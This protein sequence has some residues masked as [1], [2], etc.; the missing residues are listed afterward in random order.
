MYRL[1]IL[2]IF[3]LSIPLNAHA[4]TDPPVMKL[5]LTPDMPDLGEEAKLRIMMHGSLTGIATTSAKIQ[6]EATHLG[7]GQSWK[8]SVPETQNGVYETIL[9]F[10]QYDM[11]KLKISIE[12]Q[13]ELDN[14]E[15]NIHVMK[16]IPG[17]HHVLEDQ[18]ELK[19]DKNVWGQP[20][21]PAVLL[22]WYA[23]A[24]IWLLFMV[25]I[26]K[27]KQKLKRASPL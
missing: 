23:M 13:N 17:Y 3:F 10:P 2:M 27:R 9:Q 21:P 4:H 24:I 26:I 11:W 5:S 12:H 7:S 22:K 8:V 15:Y 19:M 16:P 25:S 14:R 6:I 20:V 18:S 1:L